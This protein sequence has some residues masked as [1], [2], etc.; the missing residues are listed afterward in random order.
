MLH[1][2]MSD[3]GDAPEE[4]ITSEEEQ[5]E[6]SIQVPVYSFLCMRNACYSVVNYITLVLL[7]IHCL[8]LLL[9]CLLLTG[10]QSV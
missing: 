2:L 4:D 8:A 7:E 9:H 10:K 1:D 3:V 6:R 5:E